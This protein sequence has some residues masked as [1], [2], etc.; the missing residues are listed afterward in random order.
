MKVKNPEIEEKLKRKSGVHRPPVSGIHERN[1]EGVY[2]LV[3]GC[4]YEDYYDNGFTYTG[5]G[6]QY[7]SRD[8][9]LTRQNI[10]LARNCVMKIINKTAPTPVT[11]GEGIA[12]SHRYKVWKYK[13][14]RDD[15]NPVPWEDEAKQFSI[16]CPDGYLE[17]DRK[18]QPKD[19]KNTFPRRN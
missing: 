5:S 1:L 3:L 4:V 16:V 17:A 6:G 14:R 11:L 8:Q 13:L 2:S 9:T 19:N 7:L 12:S 10:A 15:P 18:S